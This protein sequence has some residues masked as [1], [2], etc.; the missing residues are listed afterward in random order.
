M[1]ESDINLQLNRLLIVLR[2]SLLQYIGECWPWTDPRHQAVRDRLQSLVERQEDG[3]RRLVEL[4]QRRGWI[5]DFGTFPTEF[6]DLHYV[7]LDFLLA[8]AVENEKDVSAEIDAGVRACAHDH[9]AFTLLQQIAATERDILAQ[10][11]A[12]A[13]SATTPASSGSPR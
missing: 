7:S 10:L 1:S 12:M 2:R 11:T 4:L 9:Q 6:T 3:V 13:R 5:I 8:E